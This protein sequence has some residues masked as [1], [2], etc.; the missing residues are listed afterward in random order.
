MAELGQSGLKLYNGIVQDDFLREWRGIEAYKRANEMR[1]NS[2]VIAALL[3][4]VEFSIGQINIELSS[5]KSEDP[6]IELWDTFVSKVDGGFQNHIRECLSFLPF[7][8]SLFEIVWGNF[9]GS[10]IPMK[11][12]PR[13]QDTVYKWVIGANGEVEGFTQQ[14]PPDYRLVEIPSSKLLHYRFRPERGNPEGRSILRP[15]WVSYYYAKSIMQIEAIGVER[16]L[17]GMPVIKLPQ[18]ADVDEHDPNSDYSKAAMIVRNIRR[19]EQEGIVLPSPEWELTLLASSGTRQFDTDKIINRYESRMLMSALAQFLMLGQEN[20]GSLAL[21]GDQSDLFNMSI[22]TVA[23]IITD[24]IST[25]LLP[26]FMSLN[27]YDLKGLTLTH[28]RVGD[29]NLEAL[30]SA[31][32]NFEAFLTPTAEDEVYVR[33]L[34]GLPVPELEDIEEERSMK[35]EEEAQ[36]REAAVKKAAPSED[37]EPDET[38]VDEEDDDVEEMNGDVIEYFSNRPDATARRAAENRFQKA[39]SKGLNQ[40]RGRLLK[41]ARATKNV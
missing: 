15:A 37:S 13:G 24:T 8:F 31:V 30:A 23:D 28:S 9:E 39:W 36:K 25:Q 35:R 33:Q 10:I 20:V 21:S 14:A 5:E 12:A 27:G 7:G 38:D 26:T 29:T 6:R 22:N 1:L 34:L 4:A 19:D 3:A 11:L 2:A 41:A 32:K 18:S 16:D 17:A 40:L